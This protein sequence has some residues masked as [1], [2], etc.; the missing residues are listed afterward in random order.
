MNKIIFG[1][2]LILLAVSAAVADVSKDATIQRAV[3]AGPKWIQADA[4]VA[5][6]DPRGNPTVLRRGTNGFTCIPGIPGVIGDDSMCADQRAMIWIKS[7]MVHAAKPAN[8]QPG[9][10]YM[11]QGGTGYSDTDPYAMKGPKVLRDPPHWM[12]VWPF[13]SKTSALPSHRMTTGTWIM[14]A[15]TPYAHLMILQHP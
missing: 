13:D 9:I 15:N 7:L 6:L 12:I 1:L 3:A 10:I 14:F 5:T 2:G 8:T 4:T 11:L